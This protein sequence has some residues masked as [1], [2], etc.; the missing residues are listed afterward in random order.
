[1]II[2][3]GLTFVGKDPFF[4]KEQKNPESAFPARV[5]ERVL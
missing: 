3:N 5:Q 2:I 4:R 1:M